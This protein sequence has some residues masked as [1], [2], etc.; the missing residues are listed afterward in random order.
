VHAG[1]IASGD[2]EAAVKWSEKSVELGKGDQQ[3]ANHLETFRSGKPWR[4]P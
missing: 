1:I 4:E 2:F 3:L